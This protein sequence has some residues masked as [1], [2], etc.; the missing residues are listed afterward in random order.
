L[1]VKLVLALKVREFFDSQ[2]DFKGKGKNIKS[3]QVFLNYFY[4][5]YLVNP[6]YI[7]RLS[8][9]FYATKSSGILSVFVGELN[10]RKFPV[11]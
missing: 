11:Y 4:P 2:I 5:P 3:L 1:T 6:V 10:G 9:N 7:C 8:M